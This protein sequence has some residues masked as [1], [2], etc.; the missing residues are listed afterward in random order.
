[1]DVKTAVK[2]GVGNLWEVLGFIGWWVIV[3]ASFGQDGPVRPQGISE[4]RYFGL[5]NQ[6]VGNTMGI[7]YGFHPTDALRTVKG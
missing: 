5:R 7:I 2:A 3:W 6:Q 1:M 4:T